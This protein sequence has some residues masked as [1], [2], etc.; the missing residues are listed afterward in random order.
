MRHLRLIIILLVILSSVA[1]VSADCM[2]KGHFNS[3][4]A[5]LN[6]I[7]DRLFVAEGRIGDPEFSYFEISIGD[8]SVVDKAQ[9][10]WSN[11]EKVSFVLQFVEN[12]AIFAVEDEPVVYRDV[13]GDYTDIFIRTEASAEDSR[14]D[15]ENLYF[16]GKS[17]KSGVSAIGSKRNVDILWLR[18]DGGTF[19]L[20]GTS[21]MSWSGEQP[22]GSQL[23]FQVVV[24][25]TNQDVMPEFMFL[26]MGIAVAG[27]VA[28]LHLRRN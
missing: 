10:I 27:I 28:I 21:R 17:L 23:S 13:Q 24:A 18:C 9:Y 19:A 1:R 20:S 7:E 22:E 3:D 15:I 4:R 11:G 5:M 8:S 16:N 14:I 6:L 2:V 25:T 12:T 26:G